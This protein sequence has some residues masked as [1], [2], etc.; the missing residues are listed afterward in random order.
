M[1]IVNGKTG[2]KI[3]ERDVNSGAKGVIANLVIG[4]LRVDSSMFKGQ[5]FG[6]RADVTAMF[7]R[8]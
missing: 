1:I 4:L 3:R 7:E 2:W 6:G 5:V 8:I